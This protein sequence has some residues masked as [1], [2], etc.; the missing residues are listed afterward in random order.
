MSEK[1]SIVSKVVL[2][3]HAAV[4]KT[5]LVKYL[6][7]GEFER[8]T[9]TTSHATYFV[10][11][12]EFT[13]QIIKLQI[14]DTAG[15]ERFQELAPIYYHGAMGAVVVYDIT[16]EYSFTRA[17]FWINELY[18]QGSVNISIILVGNKK[19]LEDKRVVKLS[20]VENF[21]N[22][23]SIKHIQTSAKT[24]ENVENTFR[25]LAHK[26]LQSGQQTKT[27][28][29]DLNKKKNEGKKKGCC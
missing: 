23:N 20:D 21:A 15:E 4:G 1:P 5:C 19:D 13:E 9:Q 18:R 29:I 3:G 16:D 14:W 10:Y 27:K 28:E 22:E 25:T 2:L 8:D 24:G 7:T 26:I 12:F 17:K 6:M 11:D